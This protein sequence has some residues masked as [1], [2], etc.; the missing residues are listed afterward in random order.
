MISSRNGVTAT[1]PYAGFASD[2]DV[3]LSTVPAAGEPVVGAV[4]LTVAD[5][6]GRFVG[7]RWLGWLE[8]SPGVLAVR[9]DRAKW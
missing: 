8:L 7:P 6:D 3:V 4:T 5:R 9:T 2:L 1:D